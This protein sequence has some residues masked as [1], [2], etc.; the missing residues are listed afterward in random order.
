M[1]YI[2]NSA[3]RRPAYLALMF[4]VSCAGPTPPPLPDG[5]VYLDEMAPSIVQDM[6]YATSYNFTGTRV[7][8]YDSGRCILT[9]PAA[10]GLAAV[11]DE[12]WRQGLTL[13]VY[14]CYRP[15]SAVDAFVS[16][17]TSE[18]SSTRATFYPAMRKAAL[19]PEGY[20]AAKSGHSRGS[21]VDLAIAPLGSSEDLDRSFFPCDRA[22]GS[23]TPMGQLDFGTAFDCFD[24]LSNTFDSRIQGM[25]AANRELLVE[26]M[27][28]HGFENYAKEWWHFTYKPE[29][30][31]EL[32]FDFPVK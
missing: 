28:R 29:P 11:Q 17:S 24:T 7:P 5:F 18:D 15:Q 27:Q 21:T 31:P 20:I 8:G 1:Q 22:Q 10:Q 13:K 14:D 30:Y 16:W 12:L 3:G 26:V 9:R 4:L 23:D 2:L 19:F 25:A 6:R 32:Y